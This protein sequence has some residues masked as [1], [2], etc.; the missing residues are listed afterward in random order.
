MWACSW[1]SP[2]AT[3]DSVLL[4]MKVTYFLIDFEENRDQPFMKPIL[5]SC[6]RLVHTATIN[7]VSHISV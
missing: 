6:H 7:I 5:N 1:G 3:Q 4:L 2:Q